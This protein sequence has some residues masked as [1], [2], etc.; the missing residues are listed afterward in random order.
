MLS[1]SSVVFFPSKARIAKIGDEGVAAISMLYEPPPMLPPWTAVV[2]FVL[3]AI[4]GSFLNMLIWRLPRGKS[5]VEPAH[6]ICPKC[7]HR[8]TALDLMPILSWLRTGGKCRHCGAPIASRY[9]WVEVLVGSLFAI[10]WLQRMTVG[11]DP[12]W[13]GF[14]AYAAVAAIL[15]AI[16]FVDWELY[17]I[18]D[19]LNAALLV[20][21]LGYGAAT[22]HLREAAMG[23]FWG[24]AL[25]WGFVFLG[26]VAFG[27]DAMGDGDVKM[28]RG[29]GALLGPTL[30]LA[31]VGLGVL[32]GLA[33]GIVG[34]AIEA[35]K[36][37]GSRIADRGGD[38]PDPRSEID[39]PAMEAT[40]ISLVLLGGVIYLFCIDVLALFVRPLE[41]WLK[42]QYG[43]EEIAED[44]T[45]EDWKPSATTIPFG[46]YLAAGAIACMLAGGPIER[47]MK[48]YWDNAT[49]ANRGMGFQPMRSRGI[50][51]LAGYGLEDHATGGVRGPSGRTP[52]GL[53]KGLQSPAKWN[54]GPV[55]AV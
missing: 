6:S 8:L 41:A 19:E 21:G 39:D 38:V 40:P 4:A 15:V 24:W 5:L 51:P 18:P 34:L 23:A 49:G 30:L 53:R 9:L 35:R 27:K 13:K 22:G 3:G 17:I 46:P 45:Q 29:V 32:L 14:I 50:L 55:R 31:N 2:G 11:L 16:I 43:E 28:M 42:R 10:V 44:A 54:K 20:V 33:G 7:G 37:R 12:D 25:I 36:D 26:R 1:V 47:G 48:A 52:E